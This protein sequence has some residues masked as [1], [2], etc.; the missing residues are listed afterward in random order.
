MIEHVDHLP[1]IAA[2]ARPD[3]PL[4]PAIL[5]AIADGITVQDSTGRVVYAN[6]TAL[7]MIGFDTLPE[8]LDATSDEILARFDLLDERGELL[9]PAELPGR[10]A[11]Q[12][13]DVGPVVVGY[14]V[15]SS[16][17]VYWSQVR[18]TPL[19]DPDGR[20]THAI[21][22]FHDVTDRMRVEADLRASE[23][24]YRELV[25]AMPQIAWTTDAGGSLQMANERWR[26][27]LGPEQASNGA[28][29][30]DGVHPDD[31]PELRRR[32]DASMASQEPL[33]TTARLR[34]HDGAWRWHLLRAVPVRRSDGAVAGWIGTSTDIDDERRSR[35]AS[36]LL[37]AAAERLDETLEAGETAEAAASIAVPELGDWAIIEVLEPDGSLRRQGVAGSTWDDETIRRVRAQA[38]DPGSDAP[39]PRAIRDGRSLVAGP[40][41]V[42]PA[43]L[44]DAPDSGGTDAPVVLSIPLV[45]RG[46]TLGAMTVGRTRPGETYHPSDVALAEDFAG[47]VALSLSNAALYAGEQAAREVAE[48]TAVRME[49][50]Q[51]LTRTLAQASTREDA[52]R[53]ATRD[54]AAA[55]GAVA[56]VLAV[57]ADDGSLHVVGSHG[58]PEELLEPL[59]VVAADDPLPI[60]RAMRERRPL[61]VADAQAELG[62]EPRVAPIRAARANPALAAIPLVVGDR[63]IGVLGL[64]F[65]SRS[66]FESADR[67]LTLAQAN[68]VAQAIERLTLSEAREQLLLDLEAQRY[69]LETV[70]RQMPAGVLIADAI[71]RLVLSNAQAGEIWGQAI[72]VDRDIVDEYRE[73]VA[74]DADGRRLE[75]G[76]WPLVRALSA[77]EVVVG[78]Q[79]RIERFDGTTGW[80]AVDAAPVRDRD[81]AIIAAV[82][83]FTDITD[84]RLAA[85]RQQFLTE[86][87]TLLASS[88]DYEETLARVMQLAVP[89][90][91]DWAVVDLID[92]QGE[93][94]RLVVA[95]VDPS[96]VEM[97]R[98]LRERYPPDPDSP[99]GT[100]AVA[101]TGRP[102]LVP[103]IGPEVF[104]VITDPEYRRIVE[105]LELRSYMAVPLISGGQTLGVISFVGA[106]S[107]RRFG[108]D[109]LRLAESLAERAAGAIDNARLYRDVGRFKAI[110][111]AT[112]DA[113]FMLDPQAQ[114]ILYANRGAVDQLGW[115]HDEILGMAPRDLITELDGP[116]L[117]ALVGPLVE[118][119]VTSRTVTVTLRHRDGRRVPVEVLLQY[120]ELPGGAGRVVA[121]A[122]DISDRVEAQARL[123]RLAEAEHARAAELNA[124]IRA[125]G[126]GVVVC[127][128]R[129]AV[130]L[131]NPAADALFPGIGAQT[132]G[133]VLGRLDDPDSRAPALGERGGPTE[134]RLAG[135]P[136]RWIELST[137]PVTAREDDPTDP[138]RGPETIVLLRDV[139]EARQRQA[140]RDTF[141]GVLSHELRTPVTTIYAGSKVLARGGL[142]EETRRSVFED[143]H[144]EAERLHRLVEDV[145]ALTRFGEADDS[146]TG[147]EPVL[148]QR[149][150]PA[151]LRSEE[152][153][154]PGVEFELVV[155]GGVPTVVADPTYVEQ[156][157]RNLLSNAAKY[158]GPGSRVQAVVESEDK[159][160]T[161]RILDDGPGF[162]AGEAERLFELF[163][164]SPSTAASASGAGIGLF[165]C[166]RLIRAM[167]GRIWAKPRSEGGAEFGFSLA[168]MDD[169]W[170]S[171]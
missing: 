156:V 52:A 73:Y 87:S 145:I 118:G 61:W 100:A 166:A 26:E 103:E 122:R 15:A 48:A 155:P 38:S 42:S 139:T 121:I 95:H 51:R 21:N 7:R 157:V 69:R 5:D 9:S 74:R 127:D 141:I 71:G 82:S 165:V 146:E 153:R 171:E 37:A 19:R 17:E 36:S 150:L 114:R 11:L 99:S 154:W 149:I 33:E 31:V 148:L 72:P 107:G 169:D 58:Y 16:G 144:V 131:A 132:Y 45:A 66:S 124:V 56:A 49:A 83:T 164:R 12:G 129:G 142:D 55:L 170:A 125:M 96:R 84:E 106:E 97:A 152:A 128:A 28:A 2:P 130:T 104:E 44:P 98:E 163:F 34:R 68:V 135:E 53:I 67:D 76:E 79:L 50:L 27:Y 1:E 4:L 143:I 81:G 126:E 158:G 160:V 151:V 115:E 119:R 54:G 70:L 138:I 147:K 57:A 133:D 85:Q 110:L 8:L 88:L 162:P 60:A 92:Q 168:R 105:D 22:T 43:D 10:L 20:V 108:D 77:G 140:V 101:R 120:V 109:D 86:A 23:A 18:A 3:V 62:D 40:G 6:G 93:L 14:R 161:V 63:A 46:R 25:E 29:S 134:L 35:A 137:Y 94:E 112:L 159:E 64:S 13:V 32:W 89:G 116:R 47:R 39:G 24:R 78:E 91:A 59:R 113:V 75:P 80:I 117:R 136:E 90:L 102:I 41:E 167:H 65:G 123:Q 111:D 30:S